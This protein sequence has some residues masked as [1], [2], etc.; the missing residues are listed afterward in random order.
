MPIRYQASEILVTKSRSRARIT[1]D[2]RIASDRPL[3][4]EDHINTLERFASLLKTQRQQLT[5]VTILR[6]MARTAL[7]RNPYLDQFAP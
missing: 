3:L 4:D 7:G 6:A 1:G 2:L 5:A